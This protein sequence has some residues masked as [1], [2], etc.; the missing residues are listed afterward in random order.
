MCG[1]GTGS[2][3]FP[4][5]KKGEKKQEGEKEGC[6]LS[7]SYAASTFV[8]Q[9]RCLISGFKWFCVVKQEKC[10][11]QK[12]DVCCDIIIFCVGVS[13]CVCVCVS[14]SAEQQKAH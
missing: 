8:Q 11:F 14:E 9:K 1:P 6:V 4:S 12:G 10:V 3:M 7:F 5:I 13:I 2:R